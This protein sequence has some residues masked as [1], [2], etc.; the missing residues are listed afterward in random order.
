MPDDPRPSNV[1]I[2]DPSTLTTEQLRRELGAE[3]ELVNAKL[4][5][6]AAR[7]DGERSLTAERF[8]GVATAVA[9][10]F[11]AQKEAGAAF[12][13]STTKEIDALKVLVATGLGDIRSRLDRGEGVTRGSRDGQADR[14]LDSGLV[15]AIA[16]LA[17]SVI[18]GAAL[19]LGLH[20]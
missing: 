15:V 8:S 6:V 4:D 9:A 7:F 17:L 19:L 5:T 2:P 18:M 20:R 16:S 3:R 1:P 14:R 12:A 13:A 11:N 10:A